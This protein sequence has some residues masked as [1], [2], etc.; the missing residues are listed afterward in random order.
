MSAADASLAPERPA[1][2]VFSL[3]KSWV[4]TEPG[5]EMVHVRYAWTAPGGQPDWDRGEEAVLL[6]HGDVTGVRS[7]VL[8]VPRFVDGSPSYALHHFFFVA[9]RGGQTTTPTFV[10]DVLARE[11]I[12][13]DG[14]GAFTSVGVSW[15]AVE[16][17]PTLAVPNHTAARMDGLAFRSEGA[18]APAEPAA[19]WEFVHAQPL[20]H[21]FRGLVWG[22][23]GSQVRY[24]FQLL[25]TGS[26]DPDD[27]GEQWAD[28]G[29]DGWVVTL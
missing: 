6:P 16:S 17:E 3:G 5:I 2:P 15:R 7:A 23:R 9:R 29:G 18:D 10:E 11:V 12:Y 24:T 8:E 25:R 19:I 21:V 13:S 4:D 22:L 14:T 1:G 28:N 27:D 20:P 26:P